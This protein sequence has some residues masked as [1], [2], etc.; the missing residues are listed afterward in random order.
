LSA[1]QVLVNQDMLRSRSTAI[2]ICRNQ[3]VMVCR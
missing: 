2:K 1:N 3:E